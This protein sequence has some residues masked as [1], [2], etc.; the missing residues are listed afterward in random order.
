M[1]AE[2]RFIVTCTGRSI[3]DNKPVPLVT[4]LSEFLDFCRE[5]GVEAPQDSGKPTAIEYSHSRHLGSPENFHESSGPV[6]GRA[7]S[8]DLGGL[9]VAQERLKSAESGYAD[10]DQLS[11]TLV[12]PE[13]L[14]D[15]TLKT[16]EDIAIDPLGYYLRVGLNIYQ[17]WTSEDFSS[18]LP[19]F[20]EGYEYRKICLEVFSKSLASAIDKDQ[21]VHLL[22]NSDVLPIEPIDS[23]AEA[24]TTQLIGKYLDAY[25]KDLVSLPMPVD[26]F[27]D[28][29]DSIKINGSVDGYHADEQTLAFVSFSDK[30]LRDFSRLAIRALALI[31]SG[32]P[33]Q[34]V[35]T[36]HLSD[37]GKSTTK[38]II[39]IDAS[40]TKEVALE[41]L[42]LLL[43]SE[44]IARA[45]A[46]PLFGTAASVLYGDEGLDDL[47]RLETAEDKFDEF[48]SNDYT[49][50]TSNELVVFGATPEFIKVY[51]DP[52]GR[53]SE[54]FSKY[55]YAMKKESISR[56]KPTGWRLLK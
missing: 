7:W 25:R 16:L 12:L 50:P 19:L 20:I 52:H 39:E 13:A 3:K 9:L 6:L 1:S 10:D 14:T 55:F 36:F 56:G 40:I 33:V 32:Y 18:V 31:A 54:F 17:E 53:L 8:H 41:K 4:P 11:T 15:P 30:H 49:F 42:G 2:Q 43:S 48:V 47:A 21:L 38:R 51:S 26:V 27:L 35:L 22:R 34:K 37:N 28:F 44:P 46:C 29:S 23:L 45:I 24:S 5:C